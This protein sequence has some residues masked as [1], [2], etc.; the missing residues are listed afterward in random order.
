MSSRIAV[1]ELDDGELSPLEDFVSINEL[2]NVGGPRA[3]RAR[4]ILAQFSSSAGSKANNKPEE[5]AESMEPADHAKKA[6][7]YGIRRFKR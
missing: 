7:S 2:L 5:T 3:L 6:K 4:T 1:D